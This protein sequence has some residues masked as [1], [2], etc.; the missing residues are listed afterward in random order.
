[1]KTLEYNTFL[2]APYK[3]ETA[4]Q[5]IA[6]LAHEESDRRHWWYDKDRCNDSIDAATR[7]MWTRLHSAGVTMAQ[8]EF[9]KVVVQSVISV[10][11]YK[12]EPREQVLAMLANTADEYFNSNQ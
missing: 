9:I 1:M 6:R 10:E 3:G 2:D 5:V 12:P 7:E 11:A 4:R 8:E